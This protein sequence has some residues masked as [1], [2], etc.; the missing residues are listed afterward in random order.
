MAVNMVILQG[1]LTKAVELREM[2]NE[3]KTLFAF[4]DLAVSE[5]YA[6]KN[7]VHYIPCVIYG[8][9]AENLSKY[10]QKG[11]EIIVEGKQQTRVEELAGGFQKNVVTNVI[12]TFH[13]VSPIKKDDKKDDEADAGEET[14]DNNDNK[15]SGV[16][17]GF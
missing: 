14:N 1:R 9:N 10:T 17:S 15:S 8:K 6:G 7:Y 11:Q 13:F 3:N 2:N 16:V 5:Y 12:S 4:F